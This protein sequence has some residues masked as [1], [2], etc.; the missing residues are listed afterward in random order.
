MSIWSIIIGALA[1]IGMAS[2]T[3][4]VIVVW[5]LSRKGEDPDDEWHRLEDEEQIEYLRKWRKDEE[6][7]RDLKR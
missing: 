3:C 1:V 6:V 7:K 4:C 2:V 5:T